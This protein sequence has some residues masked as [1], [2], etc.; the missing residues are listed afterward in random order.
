MKNLLRIS[1]HM[2]SLVSGEGLRLIESAYCRLEKYDNII[3][4]LK[5]SRNLFDYF[6]IFLEKNPEYK[7]E[8]NFEAILIAIFWHDMW[9][10]E[11]KSKNIFILIAGLFFEGI[12]SSRIFMKEAVAVGYDKKQSSSVS[13]IIREH[14]FFSFIR[15]TL[16]SKIFH[17]IDQLD[18]EDWQRQQ[19]IKKLADNRPLINLLY[20]VQGYL[21]K[22]Y[23]FSLIKNL[24]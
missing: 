6:N 12:L 19:N 15:P 14:V 4:G 7:D 23:Y 1:N 22:F 24:K 21:P 16:E 20:K 8:L 2:E 9:K 13:R 10:V 17:D 5:H 3:N 11:R 18:S